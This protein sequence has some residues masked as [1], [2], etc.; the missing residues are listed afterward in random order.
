MPAHRERELYSLTYSCDWRKELLNS[1]TLSFA[2]SVSGVRSDW[3]A[4]FIASFVPC[5]A[6]STNFSGGLYDLLYARPSGLKQVV[7]APTARHGAI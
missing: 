4:F 3:A 1:E 7:K 5:S 6:E 2:T